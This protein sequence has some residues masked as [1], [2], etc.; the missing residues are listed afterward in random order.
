MNTMQKLERYMFESG[1]VS[2]DSVDQWTGL[3]PIQKAQVARE[4]ARQDVE[5]LRESTGIPLVT[6]GAGWEELVDLAENLRTPEPRDGIEAM[7]EA[8]VSLIDDDLPGTEPSGGSRYERMREAE[9]VQ[10]L[11]DFGIPVHGPAPL[12][13]ERSL[14]PLATLKEAGL[15]LVREASAAASSGPLERGDGDQRPAHEV[16]A[17]LHRAVPH[18]HPDRGVVDRLHAKGSALTADEKH[19][20]AGLAITHAVALDQQADDDQGGMRESGWL[21]AM[22]EAGVPLRANG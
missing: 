22:S 7:R 11:V 8:G 9:G 20:V 19:Q 21:N 3:L 2:P 14:T 4:F 1:N 18:S 6:D 5:S 12:P 10:A 17:D 13:S 16:L 15:P